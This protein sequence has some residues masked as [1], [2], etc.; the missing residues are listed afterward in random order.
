MG[1]GL[2]ITGGANGL[3]ARFDDLHAQASLL[4]QIASDLGEVA[5]TLGRLA[6]SPDIGEA[7]MLCPIE[8]ARAEEALLAANVGPRGAGAAWA[9]AEASVAFL[10]FSIAAYQ[11]VNELVSRAGEELSFV[12]GFAAGSLAVPALVGS[13]SNPLLA[14]AAWA[15][16]DELV[17]EAQEFA[18]DEPW[19]QDVSARAAPGVVQG[20]VS[21][22]L[23]GNPILLGLLSGGHWLTSDLQ[24]AMNG[25]LSL[26]RPAGLLQDTGTFLVRR[27]GVATHVDLPP[28]QFL[29]KTLG[30]HDLLSRRTATVQVITVESS[31]SPAY[32]VQ[33][34]GT[35]EWHP[36][37]GDNPVDLATNV[38]LVA[39]NRTHLASAVL[40]VMRAARIPNHAPIML[41][42]HS[43]GGMVA[44]AIASDPQVRSEFNIK[45]L[46]T[47]GSPVARVEIPS[48]VAVLSI[49]AEQDL[50]PKL[51]GADNPDRPNW[52]TVKRDLARGP[53]AESTRDLMSAHSLANYQRVGSELDSVDDAA[54]AKWRATVVEFFGAGEARRYRIHSGGGR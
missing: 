26:V 5:M 2:T 28:S 39:G 4:D 43:Q 27:D 6:L 35:Q 12:G 42:G 1:D 32:I 23:G 13:V 3:A 22:M 18:H 31:S 36:V 14:T 10:R 44:A 19:L 52:V 9:R 15:N 50:V 51:D 49:E 30:Q 8:A 45:A 46:V 17:D 34:P 41:T 11:E 47:A 7:A 53:M 29:A 24:G 25:L 16:R 54:I 38:G 37:R 21:S 20:A 40:D 33:I 48:D